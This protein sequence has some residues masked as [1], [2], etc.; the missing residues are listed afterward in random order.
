MNLRTFLKSVSAD[1]RSRYRACSIVHMCVCVSVRITE[2]GIDLHLCMGLQ[3]ALVHVAH[4]QMCATHTGL[5]Y[6]RERAFIECVVLNERGLKYS[7]TT[8][9]KHQFTLQVAVLIL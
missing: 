2:V 9:C 4:I 5:F 1:L 8:A 3:F 7:R 6:G